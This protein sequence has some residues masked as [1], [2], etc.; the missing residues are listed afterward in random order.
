MNMTDYAAE[1]AAFT[2]QP[3]ARFNFARDVFDPWGEQDPS[4]RMMHWVDDHGHERF[5]TYRE[6]SRRSR[7]LCTVLHAAGIRRGD[8]LIVMLPRLVEWWEVLTACLRM[9]VIASPGTGQLAPKDLAY[10]I[11]A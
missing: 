8:T 9:G 2:W 11:E 10:R 4:K 5:V 7:Q 3:P 1:R 6:M